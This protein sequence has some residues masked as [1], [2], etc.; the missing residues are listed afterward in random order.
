RGA[1]GGWYNGRAAR[2]LPGWHPLAAAGTIIDHAGGPRTDVMQSVSRFEANL[3]KLLYFFLGREPAEGALPPV[4][5]PLPEPDCLNRPAVRLVQDALAKGCVALAARR[6]GW[7]RERHLR[8][9]GVV[10]GRLWERTP[11]RELGLRFTRHSL[12][13]LVWVTAHAPKDE[14]KAGHAPEEGL[15]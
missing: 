6:G 3:L 7:R 4:E 14:A 15:A 9:D 2:R 13:F 10:E 1:G 11:P 5:K 8:G 12:A